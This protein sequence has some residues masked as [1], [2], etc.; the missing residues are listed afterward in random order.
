MGGLSEGRECLAHHGLMDADRHY[1]GS[2]LVMFY[3]LRIQNQKA[4]R[5]FSDSSGTRFFEESKQRDELTDM[6]YA[7]FIAWKSASLP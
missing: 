7:Y 3:S 5:N 6:V 1:P 2:P 4:L